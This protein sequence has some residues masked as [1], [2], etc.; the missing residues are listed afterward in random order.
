MQSPR[1][2]TMLRLVLAV[3]LSVVVAHARGVLG[4]G[5]PTLNSPWS[6]IL[7][8]PAFLGVPIL[9]TALLFDV[10]FYF[11]CRRLVSDKP[12]LPKITTLILAL[13]TIACAAYFIF[14]WS[15]SIE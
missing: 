8:I 3:L 10:M 1:T 14:S 2:L 7:T 5:A 6:L 11:A 12:H 13:A 9:L 15:T 4:D